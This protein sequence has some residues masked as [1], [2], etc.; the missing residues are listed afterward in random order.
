MW[1]LRAGGGVHDKLHISSADWWDLL[2]LL[3]LLLLLL[4]LRKTLAKWGKRN[5]QS[6]QAK[7]PQ[8]DT[9]PGPPG[10]Q[11]NVLTHSATSPGHQFMPIYRRPAPICPTQQ[12]I[13]G[14]PSVSQ[15]P[16]SPN[17]ATSASTSSLTR[18]RYSR[19][20]TNWPK[21][22]RMAVTPNTT[23]HLPLKICNM[24]EQF[25]LAG[26]EEGLQPPLIFKKK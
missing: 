24:E 12:C 26:P 15:T 16:N 23:N 22:K 10:R 3:T 21:I 18:S 20:Q 2:L 17:Q 14:R 19:F 9:N 25:A 13:C 11:S 7:L 1:Y 6:S 5:C 8:R 4:L